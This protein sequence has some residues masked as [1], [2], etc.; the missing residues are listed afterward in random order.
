MGGTHGR[1]K[2]RWKNIKRNLEAECKDSLSLGHGLGNAVVD[3]S[4][5]FGLHKE[6]EFYDGLASC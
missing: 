2:L 1:P 5:K 4:L 3:T 6:D